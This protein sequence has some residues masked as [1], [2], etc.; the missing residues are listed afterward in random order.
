MAAD[1]G[2]PLEAGSRV[3]MQVHYNL[4][5]GAEPDVTTARLRLARRRRRDLAP[6][7]DDAAARARSSCPAARRTPT[8]PLCDRAAAVADVQAR[9]GAS[10]STANVPAPALRR[11][12]R[13]GR[14]S[15]AT[16]PSGAGPRCCAPWPGTCTC[17]AA[18]SPIEVNPGTPR[19]RRRCWTSRSGTSTT[20]RPSPVEPLRLRRGDTVRV[21]CEHDQSLRDSLPAFEGQP[22]RYVVWGEGTTDEMCLGMLLVTRP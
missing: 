12:R 22:E 17:S 15:A 4:L 1:V 6:L 16:A 8:S 11:R 13:R 20:S 2:I 5:A 21:T 7:R 3:I 14:C 9:F 10:G 19:G 18:A